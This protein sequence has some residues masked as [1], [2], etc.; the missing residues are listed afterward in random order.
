MLYLFIIRQCTPTCDDKNKYQKAIEILLQM[1]VL[2]LTD[3]LEAT[4]GKLTN[5]LI[6]ECFH[7]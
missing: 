7:K 4:A 6:L 5:R 3:V 2:V 1:I